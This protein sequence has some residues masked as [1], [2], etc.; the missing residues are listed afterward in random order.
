MGLI[1]APA[2]HMRYSQLEEWLKLNGVSRYKL[3]L[4]LAKGVI[5]GHVVDGGRFYYN[6]AEVKRDVLDKLCEGTGVFDLGKGE[7]NNGTGTGKH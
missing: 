1:E 3:E 5:K 6:A 2:L 4:W 7:N